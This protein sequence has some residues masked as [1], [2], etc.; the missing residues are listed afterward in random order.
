MTSPPGPVGLEIPQA[1]R[2]IARRHADRWVRGFRPLWLAAVLLPLLLFAGGAWWTWR[3]VQ[4][5]AEG[6]LYR[7]VQIL[8]EHALRAFEIQEAVLVAS[9]Q[10]A[11]GLGWAQIALDQDLHQALRGLERTNSV[12]SGIGLVRPDGRMVAVAAQFPFPGVDVGDREYFRL[13]SGAAPV[14][15]TTGPSGSVVGEVVVSRPRDVPVFSLSRARR[16]AQGG[17]DGVIV[18]AFAPEYFSG[19]Y[20]RI[21]E[22]KGD[23][24][25]LFRLDGA[26]LARSPPPT[27]WSERITGSP[28]LDAAAD[29]SRPKL[30]PARSAV[31]GLDRIYAVQR[32]ENY[33][34]AVGYGLSRSVLRQ[35]WG[36]QVAV[37]GVVCALAA[38]LL[39]WLTARAT[40]AARRAQVAAEARA[41]AEAARADAEAALRRSRR[42]EALGQLVAGVAHDFRNTVHAVQAGARLIDRALEQG[43]ATRARIVAGSL[44]EAAGRGAALT[45]R[46]LAAARRGGAAGGGPEAST[47]PALAVRE[48]CELLRPTLGAGRALRCE[49][50]PDLPVRVRGGRAELEAAIINLAVNARDATGPEGAIRVSATAETVTADGG[51][52]PAGRYVRI[53]VEDDGA[54]MDA[55]TLARATEA[56]FTTK[57]PGEG[58]GLGLASARGFAEQA[59][60]ALRIES[61]PGR[62]TV[63]TLW[64]PEA[65]P[66]AAPGRAAA[67]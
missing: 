62:G 23:A 46:M 52:V 33:P 39:L 61:A 64:L 57:P 35:A 30:V 7:T 20:G 38:A 59:G 56:F 47:D 8:L 19:F 27:D 6:R 51:P 65:E 54:G 1:A 34:V 13:N 29:A 41:A 55:A 32:L 10:A 43:D 3:Q 25:S 15:A 42:L 66:D 49:L 44:S 4:S 26:L 36:A 12:T 24:A 48:A 58:T 2:R 18:S 21:A 9:E 50:A 67:E 5:D 16:D 40:A 14:S 22:S 17:F 53:A 31:D 63:V 11:R 45:D 28:L 37:L 60:G